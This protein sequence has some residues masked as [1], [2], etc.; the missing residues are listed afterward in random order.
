MEANVRMAHH[1]SKI[2]P[3][4]GG[5][6]LSTMYVETTNGKMEHIPTGFHFCL[7]CKKFFKLTME[8][9]EV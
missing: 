8:L 4:C 5:R 3:K 9:E 7:K 6:L 2:H 1:L